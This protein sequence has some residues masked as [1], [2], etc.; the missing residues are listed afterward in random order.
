MLAGL[1]PPNQLK[2]GGEIDAWCTQCKADKVHRIIALV[3]PTP[4]KV[5]CLSCK[6]HHM[7]RPTQAQKDAVAAHKRASKPEPRAVSAGV[8]PVRALRGASA[9]RK[10]EDDL[11]AAWE[12]AVNGKDFAAFKLYRIDKAFAKGDLIRHSK[13]GEG[14]VATI[15]DANKCEI[16][17]KDGMRTLAQSMQL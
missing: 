8:A 3:G 6:G 1:M 7:Y 16:L 12:R 14:I 11:H 2:P 4:K 15:I 9:A 17:F 10:R 5:E 13:F